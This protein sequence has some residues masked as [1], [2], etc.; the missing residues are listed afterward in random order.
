MTA[1]RHH[2]IPQC[3]LKGFADNPTKPKL[4]VTDLAEQRTFITKPGNVCAEQHFHRINAEGLPPDA[5]ENSLAGF[6]SELAPA[7]E[8]IIARRSIGDETD[9][10]YLLNLMTLIAIKNP[11]HRE[12]F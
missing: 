10:S 4:H 9:R 6:E 12:N 11:S 7:L 2:Y 5:L 1:K 8:R 3:Y